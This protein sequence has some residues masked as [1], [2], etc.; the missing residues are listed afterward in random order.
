[1]VKHLRF[2]HFSL[3]VLC[4]SII[5][6]ALD[7]EGKIAK[8]KIQ[9]DEIIEK[10]SL[11]PLKFPSVPAN[12]NK[13]AVDIAFINK[14]KTESGLI[15]SYINE[16]NQHTSFKLDKAF[17]PVIFGSVIN[18]IESSKEF[19]NNLDYW[20]KIVLDKNI[21]IKNEHSANIPLGQQFDL[22]SFKANWNKAYQT[23]RS[24]LGLDFVGS[25]E[26]VERSELPVLSRINMEHLS[27]ESDDFF[28]ECTTGGDAVRKE[29]QKRQN[30]LFDCLYGVSVNIEGVET[31]FPRSED[32][33]SKAKGSGEWVRLRFYYQ[34][35]SVS[36]EVSV[37]SEL[38]RDKRFANTSWY[39][40]SYEEVFGELDEVAKDLD[41]E[42]ELLDGKKL[43]GILKILDKSGSSG[44]SVAGVQIKKKWFEFLAPAAVVILQLYFFHHLRA[45]RTFIEK[46]KGRIFVL[47]TPW[48]MLYV[49]DKLASAIAMASASLLPCAAVVSSAVISTPSGGLDMAVR[50]LGI[51]FSLSYS[52]S[53][54][55]TICKLRQAR[56]SL[57]FV[58]D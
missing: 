27:I 1:M 51:L 42:S 26:L 43:A 21:F 58:E 53:T 3:V 8:A 2:I 54:A 10:I 11:E 50:V 41:I 45:F 32:A 13:N 16:S 12:P 30:L 23:K 5:F 39:D 33:V 14:I 36:R 46:S 52:I 55:L 34:I 28:K 7:G 18:K 37:L 31:I 29:F 20:D 47:K 22:D 4:L 48:I 40:G 35:E 24:P 57:D 19:V 25:M 49:Q 38:L 56:L 6:I 44:L 9:L 15:G 17:S